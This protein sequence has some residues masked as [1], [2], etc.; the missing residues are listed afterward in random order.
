M[1]PE[2]GA[3]CDLCTPPFHYRLRCR[4]CPRAWD[5]PALRG[6]YLCPQCGTEHV[7]TPEAHE[8]WLALLADSRDS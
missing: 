8:A 4:S 7:V 1:I 3:F 2:R 6:P 5:E